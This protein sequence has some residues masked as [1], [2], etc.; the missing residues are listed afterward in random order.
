M[1][2]CSFIFSILIYPSLSES[3]ATTDEYS[4][5]IYQLHKPPKHFTAFFY[6]LSLHYHPF[7][8]LGSHLV[9]FLQKTVTNES[10]NPKP[11]PFASIRQGNGGSTKKPASQHP[12]PYKMGKPDKQISCSFLLF[13]IIQ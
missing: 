8:Q 5:L 4:T 7:R 6:I 11:P 1:V 13:E 3:Y 2:V 12:P 9:I 10:S